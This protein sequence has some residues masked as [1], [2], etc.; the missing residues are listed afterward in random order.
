LFTS[1][2][3]YVTSRLLGDI[4]PYLITKRSQKKIDLPAESHASLQCSLTDGKGRNKHSA[5]P[6]KGVWKSIRLAVSRSVSA[7]REALV[8][9]RGARIQ[10]WGE[11]DRWAQ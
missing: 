4:H 10:P 2:I 8:P 9:R 1:I 11:Y 3:R 6:Y 5:Q 7:R